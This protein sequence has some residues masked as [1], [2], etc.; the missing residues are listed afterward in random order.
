LIVEQYNTTIA[1]FGDWMLPRTWNYK[2]ISR[3]NFALSVI[4]GLTEAEYPKEED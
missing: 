3:A 2:A 1:D 4:N